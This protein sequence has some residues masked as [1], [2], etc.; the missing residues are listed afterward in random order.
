MVLNA[1]SLYL[2]ILRNYVFDHRWKQMLDISALGHHGD[3]P[4]HCFQLGS[5]LVRVQHLREV[6]IFPA[7]VSQTHGRGRAWRVDVHGLRGA[8]QDLTS[9]VIRVHDPETD[10]TLEFA[11]VRERARV[12]RGAEKDFPLCDKW[13]TK[14]AK[15]KQND[16]IKYQIC[17]EA[18]I[19]Y[20]Y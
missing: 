19:N 10:G 9:A 2:N 11:R 16:V 14:R 4:L 8:A 6:L 5:V 17:M 1:L 12:E 3:D 20:N 13:P 18:S 15:R 7:E